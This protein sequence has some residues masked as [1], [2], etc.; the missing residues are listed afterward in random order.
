MNTTAIL[1]VDDDPDAFGG[2]RNEVMADGRASLTIAHPDDVTRDHL[3]RASVVLVDFKLEHWPNRDNLEQLSLKPVNGLSLLTILQE[4][5]HESKVTSPC[6]FALHT[7]AFHIVARSLPPQPH[8]VARAHNLEWIF[9]KSTPGP[10]RAAQVVQLAAAVQALPVIWPQDSAPAASDALRQWLGLNES[11]PWSHSAWGDV[12]RCRPPI[13]EFAE[14]TNGVG[15]L[16]WMLH[17]ILPYPCFLIDDIHLAARLRITVESL[18]TELDPGGSLYDFLR[19]AEYQGQLKTFLGRRWWRSGIEL[20]LFQ[21]TKESPGDLSFLRIKLAARY[22][23]LVPTEAL[24]VYPVLDDQFRSRE[25]LAA[26]DEV[27]EI[28]PDDWPPFA[29]SAWALASDLED[30]PQ[31]KAIGVSGGDVEE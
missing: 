12:V 15:V 26:A 9:D 1:Y 16:R 21:L 3:E 29:D 20:L 27:V 4:H 17:R 7:G 19:T 8:I 10:R 24:H 22:P 30:Y 18:R 14:H 23:N 6:A 25:I 13:H 31:L 5:L 28:V 11:A 2:W